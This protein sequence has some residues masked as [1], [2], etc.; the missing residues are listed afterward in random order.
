MKHFTFHYL[1]CYFAVN[2]P[3]YPLRVNV[4]FLLN[5]PYGSSR[6]IHFEYPELAFSPDFSVTNF[7]GVVRF[8]RAVQGILVEADFEAQVP[9]VCVRCLTDCMSTL[10]CEYQELYAF[11]RDDMTESAL[12]LPDDATIDL[13]YLTA[14]YLLIE[15]PISPLCSPDC[16]G[17]CPECGTDLNRGSCVHSTE[18]DG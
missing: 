5:Q 17:L 11:S 10:H 3:R 16:K 7:H 8:N 15:I 2:Y 4:G 18:S 6:D 12:L 9:G 13:A 1:Y 14:E